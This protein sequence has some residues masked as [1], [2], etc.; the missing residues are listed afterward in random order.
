M[1]RVQ[2][3]GAAALGMAV[4]ALAACGGPKTSTETA[5]ETP[6]PAAA[7]G[8]EAAVKSVPPVDYADKANWLCRP[9]AQDACKADISATIVAADGHM[10]RE[11]FTPD[12][13]A[14]ID[15]F[16]VYPTAS[17]D[18]TPNSDMTP[19]PEEAAMVAQQLIRFGSACRLY[20]PLYRQVTV[21]AMRDLLAGQSPAT[22]REMAY[23]DIKAAWT[24][25][26]AHDNAG[27]GV[28]LIGHDQG[29]GI[30]IR[31]IANEIDG[32]PEQEKLVS[33]IL[34][35]VNLDVPTGRN[36][37]GAFKSVPL[38]ASNQQIGCAIA[39]ASFR[40]DAPP[41]AESMFGRSSETGME[42]A[43][44]NPAELDGS[45]G[46]LKAYLPAARVTEN[47][48]DPPPWTTTGASVSTPFVEVPGLLSARCVSQVGF[49]YLAI[50]VNGDPTD[51]RTDTI[52]G[53]MTIDGQVQ[54]A[55][56]LHLYDP[57]LA[58]GNL[59]DVVKEQARAYA[60][61]EL[62]HVQPPPGD[63]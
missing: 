38:C 1:R 43:C 32:K 55:W 5:V 52:G 58:M 54:P 21:P 18:P 27:R 48:V 57:N 28:V 31:L 40:A 9:E 13:K 8:G 63:R 49:N 41:P 39:Y 30:L 25:Y 2:V 11:A 3:A 35:G 23:A 12:P 46:A 17:L 51:A 56:G 6:A 22:D 4:V 26:L 16:Y 42:A 7:D 53:D 33:T 19:G 37:G 50:T 29:A 24:H 60:A 59:V 36:V 14:P 15:C 45:N 61:R 44:V 20:A 10:S 62:A 47:G 34:L